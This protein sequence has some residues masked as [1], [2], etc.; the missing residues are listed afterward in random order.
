MTTLRQQRAVRTAL[1]GPYWNRNIRARRNL[2]R[3]ALVGAIA[4]LVAGIAI[5]A[6]WMTL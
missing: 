5:H 4:G 6:L 1:E 2:V 3:G